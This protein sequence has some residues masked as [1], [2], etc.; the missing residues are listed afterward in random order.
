MDFSLIAAVSQNGIIGDGE[1]MPWHL[2]ADLQY[3]KAMTQGKIVLMGRKTYASIGR[4]L[5]KRQNVVLSRQARPAAVPESVHWVSSFSEAFALC[6]QLLRHRQAQTPVI[7][8][9]EIMVIGGGEI[10]AALLPVA[11]RLYITQ[12]QAAVTGQTR[13]PVWEDEQWRCVQRQ[14]RPADDRNTLAC[15]FQIFERM[16]GGVPFRDLMEGE[17]QHV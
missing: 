1:K 6:E 13:F 17:Y 12:V 15:D 16:A 4:P 14:L 3:F 2:P 11:K 10:Y 9:S 7:E 5:P 8:S